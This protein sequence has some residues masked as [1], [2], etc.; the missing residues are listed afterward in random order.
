MDL[1]DDGNLSNSF[2]V[3]TVRIS[4]FRCDPGTIGSKNFSADFYFSFPIHPFFYPYLNLFYVASIFSK[5][6]FR[7]TVLFCIAYHND[8]CLLLSD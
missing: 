5:K 2:S 3:S 4:I 8:R 1:H 6:V 7:N